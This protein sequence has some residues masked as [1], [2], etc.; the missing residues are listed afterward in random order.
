MSSTSIRHLI[1]RFI[2]IFFTFKSIDC[3]AD[4]N[5]QKLVIAENWN[6]N[7]ILNRFGL[8]TTFYSKIISFLTVEG[9][10]RIISNFAYNKFDNIESE[11]LANAG[12]NCKIKYP[13]DPWQALDCAA[14]AAQEYGNNRTEV[15]GLC[16]VY[17]EALKQVVDALDIWQFK[18]TKRAMVLESNSG[19][20]IHHVL[21]IVHVS[22][23]RGTMKYI[24]DLGNFEFDMLPLNDLAKKYHDLNPDFPTLL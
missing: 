16:R 6:E 9:P 13:N 17:A 23:S 21:N 4:F 5:N 14:K 24:M 10:L 18:V 22:T 19:F 7:S 8:P 3:L 15:D 2:F 12:Y 1:C 20:D 11:L